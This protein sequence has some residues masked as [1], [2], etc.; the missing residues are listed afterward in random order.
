MS[1]NV[2]VGWDTPI[3]WLNGAITQGVSKLVSEQRIAKFVSNYAFL[4]S[5]YHF[6]LDSVKGGYSSTAKMRELDSNVDAMKAW[7][8]SN[9]GSTWTWSEA[10]RDNLNSKLGIERLGVPPWAEIRHVMT[11]DGKQ[12]VEEHVASRVRALTS[13]FF[14]FDP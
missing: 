2:Y 8:L 5:N 10:A 3:E 9:I 11:Q 6:L 7:L 4:D 1:R 14:R 12:S 13:T